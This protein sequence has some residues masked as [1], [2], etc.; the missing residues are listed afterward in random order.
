MARTKEELKGGLRLS[1]YLSFGILA[2]I[3]P[4]EIILETLKEMNLESERI[5]K[6][7]ADLMAYYVIMLSLYSRVHI[8][9]VLR[10]LLEGY[11]MLNFGAYGLVAAKSAISKARGRLGADFFKRLFEKI[12]RPI[13]EKETKGA[14]YKNLRLVGVDGST[15][16][17]PD[18]KRNA[19]EFGYPSSSRGRSAFPQL[20]FAG[21][22]EIGTRAI[23]AVQMGKY[24]DSEKKLAMN[25]IPSL[26]KDMLCIADRYYMSFEFC[27]QVL[28][29]EA[30]FLFR[31]KKNSVF[32]CIKELE[33]GSYI[34][35]IYPDW[36]NKRRGT[37]GIKVRVIE[38]VLEG[39][40]D[41]KFILVT[42]LLNDKFAPALNI[43]ALYHERWEVE[44][45]YDEM[46]THLK[47][48]GDTLRSKTPELIIQEFYGYMISH[49]IIRNVIHR[50]AL[51]SGRDPDTIS[52]TNTV[53]VLKRKIL[54]QR[55]FPLRTLQRKNS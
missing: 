46:K 5:R 25:L 26:Q 20:R 45:A 48:P 41:E 2:G 10:C 3:V 14:W 15:L 18:E 8:R 13:A 40:N 51:K 32:K 53:H 36:T 50:A 49:F 27:K 17:L 4:R 12:A 37:K 30:N 1:D 16:D 28:K 55:V 34:S 22:F 21:M 24:K 35:E 38:Y 23:F 31:A 33:D 7:P 19:S 6:L 29:Q 11:R 47:Q 42:S 52:F 44:I 9:E 39:K 43:I 54:S